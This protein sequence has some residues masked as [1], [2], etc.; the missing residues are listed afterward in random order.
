VNSLQPPLS[1]IHREAAGH[2]IPW[3]AKH[4]TGVIC[5][6]PMQSGLLT[7]TFTK[8]HVARLAADDWRR[9]SPEF[10]EPN[11]M[12]NL[13]L[14]DA[15]RPIAKRHRTP[16]TP[17]QAIVHMHR[18]I[19]S[20]PHHLRDTACIVAVRLVDLRLQHSPHVPR[21][22]TDHRQARLSERAIK[23]LRQRPRF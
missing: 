18:A 9:R 14:R 22:N 10:Q 3:Y 17:G 6:R 20:R 8:E 7:D 5:Y 16:V 1:L 13:A 2:E 4:K 21:L 11:L 15:L 23:P 12:R 19:K